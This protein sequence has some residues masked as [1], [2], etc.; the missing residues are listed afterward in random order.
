M[1]PPKT[2]LKGESSPSS[3]VQ[4]T[5]TVTTATTT[6]MMSREPS[7]KGEG[8]VR[9]PSPSTSATGPGKCHWAE[10]LLLLTRASVTGA[11][12]RFSDPTTFSYPTLAPAGT[13]GPI[14]RI[15][16]SLSS[17]KNLPS[18]PL[19]PQHAAPPNSNNLM[20]FPSPF[21][22]PG[23]RGS[24]YFSRIA[25]EEARVL[26][27]A[28]S[29]N[30]PPLASGGSMI[31]YRVADPFATFANPAKDGTSTP[32]A[33]SEDGL[34]PPPNFSHRHRDSVYSTSGDSIVSLSSDSKYPLPAS[35]SQGSPFIAYAFDPQA[36]DDSIDD[37]EIDW[38]HDPEAAIAAKL[39]SSGNLK[40]PAAGA[41][42]GGPGGQTPA[43]LMPPS[44]SF[45]SSRGL[46]NVTMLILLIV[47]C[48][49]LFIA[50]PTVATIRDEGVNKLIAF[51]TRI[52]S[53]GQAVDSNFDPLPGTDTT[54]TTTA[55]DISPT[56]SS[57]D[58]T[59][60]TPTT[61]STT[62][63][64]RRPTTTTADVSTSSSTTDEPTPTPLTRRSLVWDPSSRLW[65]LAPGSE[66]DWVVE[67]D[68]SFARRRTWERRGDDWTSGRGGESMP[69]P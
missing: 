34:L 54:T 68:P 53:T 38:L 58:T 49:S 64:A 65:V 41:A 15:P 1:L 61:T 18:S 14:A 46:L 7:S 24:H 26:G 51:N 36:D 19:K 62:T 9:G 17:P 32:G 10:S 59:T 5:P 43:Y 21:A 30:A 20:P 39:A 67:E 48:L 47:A 28:A 27:S 57:T 45:L 69:K 55:L 23:D 12:K 13:T 40:R 56:T 35:A 11:A 6:G 8:S 4:W 29:P 63:T 37:D 2:H 22:R 33:A 60:T 42:G 66:G 52:N 31:L 16:R 25:S 3:P 44:D 50:Y